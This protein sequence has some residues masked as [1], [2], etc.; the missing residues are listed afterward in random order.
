MRLRYLVIGI[1]LGGMLGGFS[2]YISGEAAGIY[3]QA[4]RVDRVDNPLSPIDRLVRFDGDPAVFL[5]RAA[6]LTTQPLGTPE[7]P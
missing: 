6:T 3:Q 2:G 7:H 1:V 5:C 4:K